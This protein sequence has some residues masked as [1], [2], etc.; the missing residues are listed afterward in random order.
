M[1]LIIYVSYV[2]II[3]KVNNICIIICETN[4]IYFEKHLW[5]NGPCSSLLFFAMLCL[6]LRGEQTLPSHSPNDSKQV[7]ANKTSIP[8]ILFSHWMITL[9]ILVQKWP[10]RAFPDGPV[11]WELRSHMASHCSQKIKNKYKGCRQCLK[12][13]A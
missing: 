2:C 3:Y 7:S 6:W 9:L 13:S 8:Y 5:A 4:F 1:E 10:Q 12:H 11:V